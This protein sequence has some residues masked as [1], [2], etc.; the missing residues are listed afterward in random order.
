MTTATETEAFCLHPDRER[1]FW[2]LADHLL[3]P[4]TGSALTLVRATVTQGRQALGH[5]EG[6]AA[7]RDLHAAM[8]AGKSIRFNARPGGGARA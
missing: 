2:A 4:V 6:F 8:V 5:E 3:L 1:A 7:A